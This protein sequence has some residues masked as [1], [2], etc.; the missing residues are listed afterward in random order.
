[1]SSLNLIIGEDKELVDFY[2]EN[3]FT[4]YVASQFLINEIPV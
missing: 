3:I 2:L 4:F 1:M